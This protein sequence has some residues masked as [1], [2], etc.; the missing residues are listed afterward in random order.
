MDPI[1]LSTPLTRDWGLDGPLLAFRCHDLLTFGRSLL[2]LPS[3][4][5][6]CNHRG[7]AELSAAC[8]LDHQGTDK[9]TGCSD[10]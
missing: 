2:R 4:V 9:Y 3:S 7:L 10:A 8:Y 5:T 1:G 6:S